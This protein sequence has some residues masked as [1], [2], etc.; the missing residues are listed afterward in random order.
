MG[1]N[2]GRLSITPNLGD[3]P[4]AY[5]EGGYGTRHV[6]VRSDDDHDSSHDGDRRNLDAADRVP[7]YEDPR[8]TGS[9]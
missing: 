8:V 5:S 1:K 4:I 3:T 2:D 6:P 7:L 9:R